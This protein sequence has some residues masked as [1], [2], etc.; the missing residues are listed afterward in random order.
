[1][2]LRTLRLAL[3]DHLAFFI[4]Q[5]NFRSVQNYSPAVRKYSNGPDIGSAKCAFPVSVGVHD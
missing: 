3:P 4:H 1:M 5:A 2:D